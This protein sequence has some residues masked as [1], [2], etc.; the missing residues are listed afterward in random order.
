MEFGGEAADG[1]GVAFGHDQAALH[2]VAQFADVAVPGMAFQCGDISLVDRVDPAPH[3]VGELRRKEPGIFSDIARPF[4]QRRQVDAENRKSEEEV[5]AEIPGGDLLFEVAVRGGDD[6]QVD[7]GRA[8]LADFDELAA[9]EHAQQ[10]GLQLDGHLADLVEEKRPLVGLLEQPFLILGGTREAAGTV[11]EQFA[12]EQFLG[13]SRTVDGDERPLRARAGV[14]DG[15]R[16]DLLAGS[17]FTREQHRGIRDGDLARQRDRTA[18]GF[19]RTDDAVERMLFGEFVLETS[20]PA[21]HLCL[22]GGTAQQRQ[23]LVVVVAL[24]YVIEC[25]VLDGLHAVG[26]IAVGRQQ[27][28]LG[29][30]HGLLDPFDH[31]DT[32][33]VGQLDV[34]QHDIGFIAAEHPEPPGTIGGL[35]HLVTFQSDD[36]GQQLAQL[37]FVVDNKNLCHSVRSFFS[38]KVTQ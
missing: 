7:L 38:A 10:L 29:R 1:E 31:L 30:R 36:A 33:A 20:Q 27:D 3:P 19:R 15:L 16:K 21:L 14:V 6:P 8:G 11:A 26:D 22:L 25:P 5:F 24:G 17:G 23:Y 37:F 34:A 2:D 35:G 18:E 32:V 13:E 9:F 28:D 4:A 12:F